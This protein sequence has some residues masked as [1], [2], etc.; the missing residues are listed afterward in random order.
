MLLSM[1]KISLSSSSSVNEVV[2]I[3]KLSK[4][5]LISMFKRLAV[6]LLIKL[7]ELPE[8]INADTSVSAIFAVRL[9]CVKQLGVS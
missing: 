6:T 4:H 2:H 8:S 3:E 5:E 9:A 1:N 7:I